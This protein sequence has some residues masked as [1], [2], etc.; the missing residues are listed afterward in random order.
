MFGI[1]TKGDNPITITQ[2]F[3]SSTERVVG[4]ELNLKDFEIKYY[5]Y[6][7]SKKQKTKKF[8]SADEKERHLE[9]FPFVEFKEA[10][11]TVTLNPFRLHPVPETLSIQAMSRLPANLSFDTSHTRLAILSQLIGHQVL[12]WRQDQ[13]QQF[14]SKIISI[15]EAQNPPEHTLISEHVLPVGQ[16]TFEYAI[17][18]FKD[19]ATLIEFVAFFQSHKDYHKLSI[20]GDR[21]LTKLMQ[22]GL[23]L[24]HDDAI[25]K[26]YIKHLDTFKWLT[27]HLLN[28]C[29]MRL[30]RAL[31]NEEPDVQQPVA[32][33]NSDKML[34]ATDQGKLIIASGRGVKMVSQE[35]DVVLFSNFPCHALDQVYL[36]VDPISI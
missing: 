10:G 8:L 27:Q 17:F 15:L 20:I 5:I 11:N 12:V 13:T 6:R 36:K 30:L 24:K 7:Y 28:G 34:A 1:T 18:K 3:H 4:V 2:T 16:N 21:E 19:Q 22:S 31:N 33:N 9:W 25:F 35:A 14:G 29:D 23:E 26:C 32:A